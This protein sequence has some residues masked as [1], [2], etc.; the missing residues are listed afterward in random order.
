MKISLKQIK[1]R[2][3]LGILFILAGTVLGWG[4]LFNRQSNVQPTGLTILDQTVD[5]PQSVMSAKTETPG[6][7]EISGKAVK[8]DIPNLGISLP[9]IDG[10]YNKTNQTWTLTGDKAQFA[11]LTQRPNNL[12]GI[13][14]IYGHNNKKVFNKLPNVK[15]GDKAVITTDNGHTF[16]YVFKSSVT[17]KP[18]DS[19]SM[20]YQGKPIL[21]LQTCTGLWYQNR[22]LYTFDLV[23]AK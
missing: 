4:I 19:S 13:T 3:T 9:V 17:T 16:T 15:L 14:F 11:T 8:L 1:F 6:V 21:M 23:E 7:N 22:S 20:S 18:N 12:N 5:Q 2:L 10:Y